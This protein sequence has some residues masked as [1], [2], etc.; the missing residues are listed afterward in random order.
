MVAASRESAR[1]FDL[2]VD[3]YLGARGDA[4]DQLATLLRDDPACV[5]GHC[6][7]GYLHLLSSKRPGIGRAAEAL[8]R[9][10]AAASSA[11]TVTARERSHLGALA[12]WAQGDMRGA[13]HGWDAALAAG[14]RD[15]V[16]LKVS[17]FVLSY[18]G[19]S[20]RMRENV[21]RELA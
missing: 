1:R 7:D 13:V 5:L 15:L 16:A 12:A 8:R 3:A 18:L 17:Q 21:T 20:E 4:P 9:A 10:E 11:V 2:A 14:A 6:L 19:E